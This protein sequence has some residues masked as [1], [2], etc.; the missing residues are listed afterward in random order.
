M[1]L[2][3]ADVAKKII[4]QDQCEL[5][6][7]CGSSCEMIDYI[8]DTPTIKAELVHWINMDEDEPPMGQKVLVYRAQKPVEIMSM[9]YQDNEYWWRNDVDEICKVYDNDYWMLLPQPP[10]GCEAE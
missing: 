9:L 6:D 10:K 8:E 3:D 1:R 4:C 7:G 5:P 2:I